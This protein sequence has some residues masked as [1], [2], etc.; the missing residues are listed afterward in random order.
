VEKRPT[1]SVRA[2]FAA[3]PGL[4]RNSTLA[5]L[6]RLRRIRRKRRRRFMR[7]LRWLVR[8][9]VWAID[10]T[11]LDAPVDGS[12]RR[13]LVV[14]ELES[15]DVLA[16]RAVPGERA[17]ATVAC[18]NDLVAAHG[19]P[20]VLKLDN[21]SAFTSKALADCCESHGIELLHSPVRRPSY[22]GS[23]EVSGRWAKVRAAA[24]AAARG[25]T[26][27]LTQADLDEAVTFTDVM[28]PID[29]SF[30]ATFRAAV[31]HELQV[32]ADAAGLALDDSLRQH[33]RRS[34]RRVAVQQAL[35]QC[36]ILTIEGRAYP[37]RLCQPS[38]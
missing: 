29:D 1:I 9:A 11:W 20:L 25:A 28:P 12:G 35:Q 24:A 7:R 31:A 21:G 19:A 33:Q 13:A 3:V 5:Y 10:G 8:G 34:L 36:H 4:P 26:S 17:G 15:K 32:A 18:I 27:T 22:N 16:L 23:C 2:L 37:R 30:R 6:R 14:V 38:S